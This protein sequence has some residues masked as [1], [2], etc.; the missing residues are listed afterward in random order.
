MESLS[1]GEKSIT[2]GQLRE[3]LAGLPADTEIVMSS[4]EEGNS[5][6][7]LAE[8][9][10]DQLYVAECTWSGYL[11]HEDDEDEDNPVPDDAQ[12]VVVLWP[13]N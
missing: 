13:T 1:R 7:P 2:A 3:W 6:S 11:V 4:D 12:H 10:P 8:A 9:E 5:F